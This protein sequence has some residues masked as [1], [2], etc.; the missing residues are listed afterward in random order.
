MKITEKQVNM[1]AYHMMKNDIKG[2][3]QSFTRLKTLDV[4]T[5][6]DVIDSLVNGRVEEALKQL[7]HLKAI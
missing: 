5:A 7:E 6:S 4:G 3:A 2:D 1:I